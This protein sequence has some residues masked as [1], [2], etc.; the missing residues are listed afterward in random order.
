MIW[1]ILFTLTNSST[2]ETI[3][4]RV[5]I[6]FWIISVTI[7]NEELMLLTSSVV[8]DTDDVN[9]VAVDALILPSIFLTKIGDSKSTFC[10]INLLNSLAYLTASTVSLTWVLPVASDGNR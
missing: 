7:A 9:W 4:G 8:A 5:S 6:P 1:A 3:V 10:A 2:F